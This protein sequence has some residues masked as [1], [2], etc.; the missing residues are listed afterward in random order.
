MFSILPLFR[1]YCVILF[2][3]EKGGWIGNGKWRRGEEGE[4]GKEEGL[5]FGQ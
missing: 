4:K 1:G 5:I 3:V 2:S